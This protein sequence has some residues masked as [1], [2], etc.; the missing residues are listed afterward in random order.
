VSTLRRPGEGRY[1]QIERE[2]RWVLPGRPDG[3]VHPSSIVDIYLTGTRLR[4]RRVTSGA[5]VVYKLGQKVRPDERSPE[6]VK[7]TN[8]YL[9]FEEYSRLLRL[10]GSELRK[11][12]WRLASGP[13]A[14]GPA[15]HG[16][17]AV[18]VDEF[19]GHLSGL[20]LAETELAPDATLLD[21]PVAGAVDVT[22]D[23]RFS[24]GSLAHR[25]AERVA[26]LFAVVA[27]R[28][29]Q[30]DSGAVSDEIN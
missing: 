24:G 21:P 16:P 6:L 18:A 30:G 19:H 3:L 25:P 11:T 13:A 7:L 28:W 1:A 14:H 17:A 20:F 29:S 5:D 10:P 12:R 22:T 27:A 15:A 8:I 26:E 2:Q 4:L 9:S 23:D